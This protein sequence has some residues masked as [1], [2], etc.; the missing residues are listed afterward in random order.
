MSSVIR[1]VFSLIFVLG[2]CTDTTTTA[3]RS[4]VDE[5]AALLPFPDPVPDS[6]TSTTTLGASTAKTSFTGPGSP[7]FFDHVWRIGPLPASLF[8]PVTIPAGCTLWSWGLH[9]KKNSP[10]S[11]ILVGTLVRAN[12]GAPTSIGADA[13]AS[14]PNPV[15]TT[16]GSG[17]IVV[18]IEPRRDYSIRASRATAVQ[19]DP[20]DDVYWAEVEWSCP[21]PGSF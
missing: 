9:V 13:I 11:T 15:A 21:P 3:A 16:I 18:P 14:A 19:N 12:S 17:P 5:Q 7:A 20:T 10:T 4:G 6:G 8:F 1:Y 2:A